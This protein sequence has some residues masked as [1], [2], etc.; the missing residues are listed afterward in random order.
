MVTADQGR[1]RPLVGVLTADHEGV[2]DRIV[3]VDAGG[4]RLAYVGVKVDAQ[5]DADTLMRSACDRLRAQPGLV[6]LAADPLLMILRD[7]AVSAAADGVL[8]LPSPLLL[9]PMVLKTLAPSEQLLVLIDVSGIEDL[10]EMTPRLL[11][12]GMGLQ[13]ADS[14][15]VIVE[16][17]QGCCIIASDLDLVGKSVLDRVAQVQGEPG[18]R[19]GAIMVDSPQLIPHAAAL[20]R[21]CGV[22]VFDSL[23]AHSCCSAARLPGPAEQTSRTDPGPAEVADGQRRER[24][25]ETGRAESAQKPP[26]VRL[27]DCEPSEALRSVLAGEP[28]PNPWASLIAHSSAVLVAAGDLLRV[29]FFVT[30]PSSLEYMFGTDAGHDIGFA[31]IGGEVDAAAVT[32]AS[33]RP[34]LLRIRRGAGTQRG[35]IGAWLWLE[36]VRRPL[37]HLTTPYAMLLPPSP[38]VPMP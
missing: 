11:H 10:D 37:P 34:P 17:V 27:A 30:E 23:T 22:P 31:V 12:F 1:S 33:E 15:R 9:A 2:G 3:E 20:R 4:V 6:A 32:G 13:E 18:V 35:D 8:L 28:A 14:W 21:A 25:T 7:Q 38:R 5:A 36:R 16:A 29:P 24:C 19:V 26:G